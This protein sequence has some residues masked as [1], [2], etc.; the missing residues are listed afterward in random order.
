[1]KV[2]GFN[3][4]EI[5]AKKT[6]EFKRSNINTEVT[7]NDV[8]KTNLDFLKGE[9]SIKLNFKFLVTYKDAD[10]ISTEL[11]NE[12]SIGGSILLVVTKDE[13]KEFLKS[14]KTKELPKDKMVGLYNF[15]LRKCSVKALQLEEELNLQ[16]HIPFPQVKAQNQPT[17]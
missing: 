9:E 7:F 15:I 6:N 2:V 3:F 11:K 13:S 1:M 16:P 14:W 4:E 10:N 12:I 8:A 17:N 5:N